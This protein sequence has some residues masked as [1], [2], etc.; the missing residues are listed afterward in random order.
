MENKSF[1]KHLAAVF[2][3]GMIILL[4]APYNLGYASLEKS[5]WITITVLSLICF[6]LI[7][8]VFFWKVIDR[9]FNISFR[10]ALLALSFIAAI[11]IFIHFALQIR[12]FKYMWSMGSDLAGYQQIFWNTVNSGGF[13][14]SSIDDSSCWLFVHFPVRYYRRK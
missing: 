10:R 1:I 5:A 4:A 9:V 12:H 11:L 2:F 3:S 13:L 14:Y 8:A 7:E 6:A